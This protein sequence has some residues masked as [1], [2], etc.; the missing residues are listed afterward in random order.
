MTERDAAADEAAPDAAEA[1]WSALRRLV[2]VAWLAIA[3]GLVIQALILAGKLAGGAPLPGFQYLANVAQGVTWSLIVCLGVGI[4]TMVMRASMAFAGAIGFVSAPLALG[5]A[6]GVQRGLSQLTEGGAEE[7]FIT[8][9]LLVIALIKAL[10]YGF[11]TYM[12]TRLVRRERGELRSYLLLGA[13]TGI[14]FGG[15][16]VFISWQ[17]AGAALP[18]PALIGLTIN[19]T[20]FPVGCA[21]VI[22]AIQYIG[23]HVKMIEAATAPR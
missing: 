14:V 4:G 8:L 21:L 9:A 6:K 17:L 22:F 16:I 3:L 19:E 1:S 23:R 18:L 15:F 13:G 2:T 10:E 11:L 20:L 12:L 7:P 5:G